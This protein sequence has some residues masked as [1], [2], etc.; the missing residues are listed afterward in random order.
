MSVEW[1]EYKGK[2]ILYINY[3]GMTPK[4][5]LDQIVKATEMIIKTET[6]S[7]LSLTDMRNCYVDE[8]FI[9]TAK[10]Q[11]KLSLSKTKKAAVVGIIG[12]KK[13]LLQTFNKF[14]PKPRVPFDTVE[15]AKDWLV[16]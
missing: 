6:D 14:T 11:S 4:E 3:G 16:E 2:K 5:R 8:E 7:N 10:K 13:L 9:E 1:L 12:I 15:E